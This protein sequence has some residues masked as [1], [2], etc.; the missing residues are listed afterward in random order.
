L[1]RKWKAS[2]R[3]KV[4]LYPIDKPIPSAYFSA[5]P[6]I[7]F[8]YLYRDAGNNKN[9]S[10]V[11]FANPNGLEIEAL[12]QLIISKLYDGIAFYNHEFLVPDLHFGTWDNQLDHTWHEFESIEYT[13]KAPN[14]FVSLNDFVAALHQIKLIG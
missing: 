2:S 9:F 4:H 13:A 5:M 8:S 10:S 1:E 7:E 3:L 6:N 14:F 12:S 11:I